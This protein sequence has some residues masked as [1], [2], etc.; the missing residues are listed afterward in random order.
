MKD[1]GDRIPRNHISLF[2]AF[3]KLRASGGDIGRD[4]PNDVLER[5]EWIVRWDKASSDIMRALR[6]GELVAYV[7]DSEFRLKVI[8]HRITRTEF[9]GVRCPE[10]L[11]TSKRIDSNLNPSL[12]RH[13]GRTPF[14]NES[15]FD[16]WERLQAIPSHS[17]PTIQEQRSGSTRRESY[18]PEQAGEAKKVEQVHHTEQCVVRLGA[19][20]TSVLHAYQKLFPKGQP[21]GLRNADRN[22]LMFATI[23]DNKKSPPATDAA[24]SKQIDRLRRL[25]LIQ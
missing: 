4:E 12:R 16:A 9:A 24:M 20:A 6:S 3:D 22:K 8:K 14:V 19:V 7:G 25:E 17:I 23:R 13:D 1:A 11:F 21:E 2:D 5:R 10:S 15:E 18:C